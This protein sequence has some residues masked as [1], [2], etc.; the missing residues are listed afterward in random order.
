MARLRTTATA[1]TVPRGVHRVR[2]WKRRP[3]SDLCRYLW[4]LTQVLALCRQQ[5]RADA[6]WTAYMAPWAEAIDVVTALHQCDSLLV[7]IRRAQ[8]ALAWEWGDAAD[9]VTTLPAG[10]RSRITQLQK[11]RV[12]WDTTRLDWRRVEWTN[13]ASRVSALAGMKATTASDATKGKERA[14]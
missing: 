12:R 5:Q 13:P 11:E 4:R 1:A 9:E 2:R 3:V 6:R 7:K 14:A 8:R 10:V